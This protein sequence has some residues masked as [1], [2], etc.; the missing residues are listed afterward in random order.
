MCVGVLKCMQEI[1]SFKFSAFIQH[2]QELLRMG[3]SQNM[4]SFREGCC[5][6]GVE[7]ERREAGS[8]QLLKHDFKSSQIKDQNVAKQRRMVQ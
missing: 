3:D 8:K 4:Q 5:S 7:S 1:M 6:P 2:L